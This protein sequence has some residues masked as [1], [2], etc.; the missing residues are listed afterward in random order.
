MPRRSQRDEVRLLGRTGGYTNKPSHALF[1]TDVGVEPEAVPAHYQRMLTNTAHR[2]QA[3][4][5]EVQRAERAATNGWSRRIALAKAQAKLTGVS[6]DRELRL[7]ACVMKARRSDHAVEDRIRAL[8]KR[9]WP[10]LPS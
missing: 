9:V 6:I 10:E 2:D 7:L 1:S 8:E 3:Q 5:R 4:A